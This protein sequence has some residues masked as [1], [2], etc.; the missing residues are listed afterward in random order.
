LEL[1]EAFHESQ[2]G[3]HERVKGL[4]MKTSNLLFISFLCSMLNL[5][6]EESFKNEKIKKSMAFLP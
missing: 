1:S 4:F 6:P 3:H 2:N 5:L